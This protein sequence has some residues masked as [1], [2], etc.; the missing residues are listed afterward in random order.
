MKIMKRQNNRL[1]IK[2][3][4]IA[5]LSAFGLLCFCAGTASA[6][7]YVNGTISV[8]TTWNSAGSPYIVDGDISVYNTTS[9]PTLTIEPGVTVK[10]DAQKWMCIGSGSD[11]GRLIADGT[12]GEIVF[13][14]ATQ[15]KGYWNYLYFYANSDG[16]RLNN[17]RIEYGGSGSDGSVYLSSA[18]VNITNSTIANSS[19]YGIYMNQASN[20]TITG[21]DIGSN[22]YGMYLFNADDN[23]LSCNWVHAN[24][25]YGYY[26]TGV[27]TGNNIS[28]NNIIT[29]GDC[30][31]VGCEW[32]IYN[33]QNYEVNA[34]Y[35]YWGTSDPD[36]INASIT[37][38]MTTQATGLWISAT[39]STAILSAHRYRNW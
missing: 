39:L 29:N 26:L 24:N 10:F 8:D 32:D 38:I 19:N 31:G 2:I 16:S 22:E 15:T 7:T 25:Q 11:A 13:T 17:T 14:G 18:S 12:T 28:H 34:T 36:V 37:I 3:A 20:C 9:T 35:S 30:S 5:V 1:Q 23:Y 4:I 21:N 6:D 27:S 33:E